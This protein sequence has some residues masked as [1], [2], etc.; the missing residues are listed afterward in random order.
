MRPD[1][2]GYAIAA[3]L[4]LAGA[5]LLLR[6]WRGPAPPAAAP[7][8]VIPAAPPAAPGGAPPAPTPIPEGVCIAR[9]GAG[10][11]FAEGVVAFVTEAGGPRSGFVI[12][13]GGEFPVPLAEASIE[14]FDEATS[15]TLLQVASA[16]PQP[17]EY[18]LPVPLRLTGAAMRG[19]RVRVAAGTD[20]TPMDRVRAATGSR[21][22]PAPNEAAPWGFPLPPTP[23]ETIPLAEGDALRWQTVWFFRG[24]SALVTMTRD[25]GAFAHW[26]VQTR[27]AAP[28]QAIGVPPPQWIRP[29]AIEIEVELPPQVP[30]ASIGVNLTSVR[31]APEREAAV[32]S[33]L[34]A[35]DLADTDL[36]EF[37]LG[38]DDLSIEAPAPL[39]IAPVPAFDSA[40]LT[41]RNDA[42]G[43]VATRE[44]TLRE[45][46]TTT[47]RIAAADLFPAKTEER[48]VEVRAVLQ[49]T[50][51]PVPGARVVAST[52]FGRV[53]AATDADGY[54]RLER[55]PADVEVS[56][57]V[58]AQD[59]AS[60]LPRWTHTET[61]RMPRI[62]DSTMTVEIPAQRWLIVDRGTPAVEGMFDPVIGAQV[63]VPGG[64]RDAT[65][66][67]AEWDGDVLY[68]RV[69]EPGDYRLVAIEDRFLLRHTNTMNMPADVFV[70]EGAFADAAP[71]RRTVLLFVTERGAPARDMA[72]RIALRTPGA[73]VYEYVTNA[74]GEIDLGPCNA[75]E[76]MA[77]SE[78]VTIDGAAWDYEGPLKLAD[79][80]PTR[81]ELREA[82]E[83]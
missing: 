67:D 15:L 24:E 1:R 73:R 19:V 36:G 26:S 46:E 53:E 18:V 10:G 4:V 58:D 21:I 27:T 70:A 20:G 76:L 64:W 44:I 54:A 83:R 81:V 65:L 34:A 16:P 42:T 33:M 39:R 40:T 77:I 80:G 7:A 79:Y 14:F 32:A 71:A 56:F 47:V 35:V 62:P 59:T 13:T 2:I 68:A 31:V 49:G 50:E 75:R 37:V 3:L 66:I 43:M 9:F 51:V 52:F 12:N 30:R 23:R 22:K 55:V 29:A 6:T 28:R 5:A 8:V 82:T 61:I 11:P 72:I 78:P 25:D 45:G 48:L 69:S 57:L 74:K 38:T 60:E 41:F 63:L 17:R